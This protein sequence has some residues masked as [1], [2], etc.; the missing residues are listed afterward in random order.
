MS[1]YIITVYTHYG[2]PKMIT[3]IGKQPK[4]FYNSLSIDEI[5]TF[6][7]SHNELITVVASSD[8]YDTIKNR[9]EKYYNFEL[10][11]SNI[12]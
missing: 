6:I 8:L 1:Q 4:V 5:L 10:A 9:L 11:R 2:Q 3:Q 7:E 12:S